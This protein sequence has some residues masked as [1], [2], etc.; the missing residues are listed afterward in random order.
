MARPL[1]I[2]FPHAYYHIMNRG[3]A[4]QL[5]FTDRSDW[6]MFLELLAECHETWWIRVIEYCLLD[7]HYHLLIHRRRPTSRGSCGTST[8]YTRAV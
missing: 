6:K 3:L 2:E 4:R 1:R 5:V 7:N 8:D